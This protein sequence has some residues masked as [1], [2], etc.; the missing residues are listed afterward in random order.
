MFKEYKEDQDFLLPPSFK[1]YLWEWHEAIIL[2]EIINELNLDKLYQEYNKNPNWNGRPAYNPKMLLKVLFYWYMNQT[3]S[4]RKLA[5]KLKSDLWFMYISWNNQADFRTINRFRKEKWSI[6]ENIFVQIVNKCYELGIIKFWTVSL[7]WTKIYA[8]ASKNKNSDIKS[9]EKKIRWLFDEADK[10]D[11]IEDEEF[12]ENNENHITEELK[13][14]EWRDKKRRE[15]E[16]KKK[17]LED[18]K[19][20]VIKEI[21]NKQK[22]WIKQERINSTDKDSRLM[23]MKR[24][25]FANWYNPQILTENQIIL[26]SIVSNSPDDSNE[27]IPILNKLKENFKEKKI[28]R[29]LADKW[30]WNEANYVHLEKNNILSYIPHPE[31]NGISLDNYIYNKEK[32]TYED[33]EWNIFKFKQFMWKLNWIWKRWRPK[34]EDMK[35]LNENDYKA[36]LYI[37]KLKDWKKKFLYVNNNL[38]EIY[39]RNDKKLYSKEGKEIYK[40]RC[41]CVEPVFGN[42]KRNLWFEKLLLRWF[43]WVQIEWNLISLAHNLKK[44]IRFRSS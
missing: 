32:D 17:K 1:E 27:L 7:D 37:T 31:N 34:K 29:I 4:S 9:L 20:E 2:S 26:T 42:I 38:K 21:E 44:I 16:E 8:N 24:K 40:K 25:D 30:Y 13:T 36:K 3:F 19:E 11:S 39:K 41:S 23:M 15:I 33:K 22:A 28:E 5:N 12:W 10:I 18:K 43:N 6:L 35:R 14:K